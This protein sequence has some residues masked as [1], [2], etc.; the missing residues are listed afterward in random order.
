MII[1]A[2]T[3]TTRA[4]RGIVS[5]ETRRLGEKIEFEALLYDWRTS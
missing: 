5:L 3:T 2:N 4:N 1:I